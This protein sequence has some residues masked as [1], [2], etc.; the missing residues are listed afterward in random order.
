MKKIT[1]YRPEERF[2]TNCT[3]DILVGNKVLTTIKNGEEKIIEIPDG[4]EN[5]TLKAKIQWCGSKSLELKN[6][7]ENQKISISG[8]EFLNK[9]MPLSGALIPLIGLMVFNLKIFP[10]NIGIAFFIVFLIGIIG[11]ITV[12]RNKWLHIKIEEKLFPL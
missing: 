10:K 2:N 12:W 5:E 11:T 9:Q 8:N 3:Y 4:L 7:S 6:I 1:I